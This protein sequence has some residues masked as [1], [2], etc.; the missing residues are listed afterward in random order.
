MDFDAIQH[1]I[2]IGHGHGVHVVISVDSVKL[3]LVLK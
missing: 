2:I 1:P 3:T